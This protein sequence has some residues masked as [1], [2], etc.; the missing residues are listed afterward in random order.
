MHSKLLLPNSATLGNLRN[1]KLTSPASSSS[2]TWFIGDNTSAATFPFWD[3]ESGVRPFLQLSLP[4]LIHHV[5]Q[6]IGFVGDNAPG[7]Y[8][9]Y[10]GAFHLDLVSVF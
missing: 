6:L 1:N 8:S 10:A 2:A 7:Y 5:E 4:N 9:D 3:S